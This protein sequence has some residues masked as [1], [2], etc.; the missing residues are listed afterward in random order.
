MLSLDPIKPYLSL[1]KWIVGVGLLVAAFAWGWNVKGN[2]DAAEM[3]GMQQ[4]IDAQLVQLQSLNSSLNAVNEQTIA[5]M[6]TAEEAR[7]LAQQA[8]KEADKV[9]DT[10]DRKQAAWDKEF[11]RIKNNP[12]CKELMER[13]LCPLI[14]DF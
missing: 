5:N 1:I 2:R 14:K 12:D 10:L 7:K 9:K 13:K 4:T 6:K 3:L 8:V 11:K